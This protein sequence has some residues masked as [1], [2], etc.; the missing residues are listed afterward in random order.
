MLPEPF[1][2]EFQPEREAV[3]VCPVGELD[4]STVEEV[5]SRIDTLVGDGWHRV[6]LDLRRT[7]FMDSSGLHLAVDVH[8]RSAGDGFGFGIIAGPPAVHRAFTITGLNSRL[9]FEDARL[10]RTRAA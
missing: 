4:V 7:T 5:R 9:P 1:S 2:V 6:V 10:H 3:R 8:E